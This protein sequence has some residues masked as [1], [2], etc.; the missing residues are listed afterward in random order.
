MIE[1]VTGVS[2]TE[3]ADETNAWLVH[4]SDKYLIGPAHFPAYTGA[5]SPRQ[6]DLTERLIGPRTPESR[7]PSCGARFT[8]PKT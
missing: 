7:R 1:A 5:G 6:K 2:I 8:A 4:A 3:L